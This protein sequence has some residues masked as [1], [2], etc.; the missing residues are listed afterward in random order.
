MKTHHLRTIDI[1]CR[2]IE[3][4]GGASVSTTIREQTTITKSAE[5]ELPSLDVAIRRDIC[6]PIMTN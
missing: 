4:E 3:E 5:A 6:L 1:G 2:C